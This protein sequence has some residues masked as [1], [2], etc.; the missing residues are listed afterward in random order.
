MA[1]QITSRDIEK[2]S[3][4]IRYILIEKN[5]KDMFDVAA[6]IVRL[7]SEGGAENL[8]ALAACKEHEILYAFGD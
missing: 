7:Q 4:R 6:F 2:A 3:D 1:K 8:V 5:G